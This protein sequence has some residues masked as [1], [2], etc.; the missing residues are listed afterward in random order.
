MA[1]AEERPAAR[2]VIV[3]AG[4][5]VLGADAQAPLERVVQAAGVSRATFYR[6]FRSRSELLR[7]LDLEPEPES[8]DRVLAAA[9]ELIGRGGLAALSMDELA[10]AAGVSRASV[11]R[12]FPGKPALFEALMRAYSPFDRIVGALD[13]A[14][15]RP[16]EETLREILRLAATMLVSRIGLMRAVFFEVTGGSP[17]AVAGASLAITNFLTAFGA[18][19]ESQMALGRLRRMPPLLAVQLLVGPL[20]F[21][22]LTRRTAEQL[23]GMDVPLERVVDEFVTAGIRALAVRGLPEGEGAS[24]DTHAAALTVGGSTDH[25]SREGEG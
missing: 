1:S 12:L 21:H 14:G 2:Q 24:V 22:L 7:A 25:E 16:P 10:D 23:A 13:E 5:R 8:R 19:L 11:Y 15:D 9:A 20:L 17:D 18:Y 3:A 4:R 6:H